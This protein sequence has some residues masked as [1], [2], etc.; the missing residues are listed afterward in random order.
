MLSVLSAKKPATLEDALRLTEEL[1][2]YEFLHIS[3]E[4][5]GKAVLSKSMDIQ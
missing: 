4:D 1:D 2:A 5:Y 3:E